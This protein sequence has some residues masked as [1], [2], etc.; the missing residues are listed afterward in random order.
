MQG[1]AVFNINEMFILKWNADTNHKHI[2]FGGNV[3]ARAA[4]NWF[5]IRPARRAG[6]SSGL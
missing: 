6:Y 1:L 2:I 4:I 3:S 5:G